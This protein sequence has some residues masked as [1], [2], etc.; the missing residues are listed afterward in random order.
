MNLKQRIEYAY[1]QYVSENSTAP[2]A[3]DVTV[4]FN[5]TG[6][7]ECFRIKFDN[8]DHS[9]DREYFHVCRDLADLLRL[10][11]NGNGNHFMILDFHGFIGDPR[12]VQHQELPYLEAWAFIEEKIRQLKISELKIHPFPIDD[13][14][15]YE[16]EVLRFT[17][18]IGKDEEITDGG[19]EFL[20]KRG[21][22][23][24]N[25]LPS[26]LR[27]FRKM[28]VLR[29]ILERDGDVVESEF[30]SWDREVTSD[31]CPIVLAGEKLFYRSPD[32]SRII[33]DKVPSNLQVARDDDT[34][35]KTLFGWQWN[36]YKPIFDTLCYDDEVLL[37]DV[38]KNDFNFDELFDWYEYLY[39]TSEECKR[40]NKVEIVYF[41]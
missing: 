7:R 9:D 6:K 4:I 41:E 39:S 13:G 19:N 8:G 36:G 10:C 14:N 18:A 28:E 40:N 23:F 38:L 37:F 17:S 15:C 21:S 11:I 32:I 31:K 34:G 16:I 30:Q 12:V 26:N 1:H 29:E 24:V 25:T 2:Y 35:A 20:Y 5:Y 27:V 33:S 22:E 3:A